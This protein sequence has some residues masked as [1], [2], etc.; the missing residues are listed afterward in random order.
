MSGKAREPVV[1]TAPADIMQ[2]AREECA[3]RATSPELAESYRAG[4][5]DHGWGL[6]HVADRIKR[7]RGL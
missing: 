3:Q 2:E 6:R 7:E 4:G 5:Q 1:L